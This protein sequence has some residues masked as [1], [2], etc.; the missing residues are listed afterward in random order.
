MT[1]K[2]ILKLPEGTHVVT[3]NTERCMVIRLRDGFTLTI[4]LPDKQILI[5]RYSERA[6]LLW[7]DRLDDIFAADAKEE[8]NESTDC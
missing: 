5:Q 4:F 6:N 2:E 1:Y 8:E 7:E 3:V